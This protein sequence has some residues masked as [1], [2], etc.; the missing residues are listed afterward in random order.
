MYEWACWRALLK[1][2]LHIHR[3][4]IVLLLW[5]RGLRQVFQSWIPFGIRKFGISS[6][7]QAKTRWWFPGIPIS[8]VAYHKFEVQADKKTIKLCQDKVSW[9]LYTAKCHYGTSLVRPDLA[10][11]AA[12]LSLYNVHH[13][14]RP[15]AHESRRSNNSIRSWSI[16]SW[17]P[18][19]EDSSS[20]KQP[21]S[22]PQ[23]LPWP[24]QNGTVRPPTNDRTSHESPRTIPRHL[25]R[26][27]RR[28][29]GFLFSIS[30]SPK[31]T[32]SPILSHIFTVHMWA[33]GT[34]VC[35]IPMMSRV[36]R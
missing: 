4:L 16:T 27:S 19:S 34:K 3:N 2:P 18:C 5:S 24:R 26:D 12:T 9:I 33:N 36:N 20:G 15:R 29:L 25:L 23:Q 11:V 30:P 14:S 10:F 7:R 32:P 1:F 28:I 6:N 21:S 17:L 35:S 31:Q 8:A 13:H 22:L